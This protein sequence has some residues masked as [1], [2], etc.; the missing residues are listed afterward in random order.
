MAMTGYDPQVVNNS[1]SKV[2]QAYNDY[3]KAM[4]T[5]MQNIFVKG[6][7]QV[8]ACVDAQD[9]FNKIYEPA[10]RNLY[11]TAE[12]RLSSVVASMN[13]AGQKWAETTGSGYSSVNLTSIPNACDVS[14][15][16]ENLSGVRGI[17]EAAANDISSQLPSIQQA[18]DSALDAA[19]QAV[20]TCGFVDANSS[21]QTAI[22]SSLTEIKNLTSSTIQEIINALKTA[23]TRTVDT[24]GTI[25]ANVSTA[26]EGE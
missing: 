11:E 12:R 13:S 21:Q 16:Q 24:Y 17:D 1:I 7:E 15:I 19:R 14:G 3:N 20:A 26:F 9:F 23:V 10:M 25:S 8:W 2:I 22:D 18:A 6:M 4:N 5:D